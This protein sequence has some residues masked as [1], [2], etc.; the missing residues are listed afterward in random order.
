VQRRRDEIHEI[1]SKC[2]AVAIAGGHVAILLNRLR[3]FGLEQALARLP[4]MAS[5]VKPHLSCRTLPKMRS[6]RIHAR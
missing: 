1:L 5:R 6:C 4:V 3:L 2:S